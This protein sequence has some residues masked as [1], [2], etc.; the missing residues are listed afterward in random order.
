MLVEDR[1]AATG[2][3]QLSICNPCGMEGFLQLS[4]EA[5]VR[6]QMYSTDFERLPATLKEDFFQPPSQQSILGTRY[7]IKGHI[8]ERD[9]ILV[10]LE[11]YKLSNENLER[12]S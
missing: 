11:E 4:H 6:L 3:I 7:R 10:W 9:D 8:A 12:K 5:S 1:Q 2:R